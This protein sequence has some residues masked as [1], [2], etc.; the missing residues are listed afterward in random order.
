MGLAAAPQAGRAGGAGPWPLLCEAGLAPR[1]AERGTEA[2]PQ[3]AAALPP[4]PPDALPPPRLQ[5]LP[6][7]DPPALPTYLRPLSP[8]PL[9]PPTPLDLPA[10]PPLPPRAAPTP[11]LAPEPRPSPPS[12]ALEPALG[13]AAGS[14]LAGVHPGGEASRS[15][16]AVP[17]PSRLSVASS[18]SAC[19]ALAATTAAQ[20]PSMVQVLA[21]GALAGPAGWAP[22][23]CRPA[24]TGSRLQSC[25]PRVLLPGHA[26]ELGVGLRAAGWWPCATSSGGGGF[27]GNRRA[28][29]SV[30]ANIC[31]TTP[32]AHASGAREPNFSRC[33]GGS[34]L[35]P[36]E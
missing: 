35:Q 16:P 17:R 34:A 23:S 36:R 19:S 28:L 31:G 18:S 8:P 11:R 7:P 5:P 26:T 2:A 27:A 24:R 25:T 9:P 33:V 10:P 6:P 13:R 29:C 22:R 20:R 30:G 12:L 32:P 21:V 3:Q 14:P 1:D 15:A 4:L